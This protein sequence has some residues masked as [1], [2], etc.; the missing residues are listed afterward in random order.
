MQ[1]N[2]RIYHEKSGSRISN[3]H[4]ESKCKHPSGRPASAIKMQD[5]LWFSPAVVQTEGSRDNGISE[6]IK[7]TLKT[8]ESGCSELPWMLDE[9]LRTTVRPHAYAVDT[10]GSDANG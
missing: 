2:D 1:I 6:S 8:G 9:V 3:E 10:G 5:W 7:V 4:H